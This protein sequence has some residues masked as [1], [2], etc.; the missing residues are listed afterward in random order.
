M[1]VKIVRQEKNIALLGVPTSSAQVAG[2]LDGAPAALRI[3]GIVPRLSE[4]GFSVN[5][6]GDCTTRVFETDDEH[7]RARNVKHVLA[8]LEELRPKVEVVIKSGALPLVLGGDSSIVLATVAGARRYFRNVSLIFFDRDAALKEPATT[9]SGSVD[10]M[11]ISHVLGRGAPEL[12]R[13][14]GEPPLVR[15]PDVALFGV[16]TLDEAE[17]QF[18]GRSPLR[19]YLASDVLRA[20]AARAAADALEQVHG[21]I[22]EFV[23]LVDFDVIA[24]EEFAAGT[25]DRTGGMPLAEFQRALA[26]F[27]SQ[28][29]LTGIVISGYNPS[30]DQKG[31]AAKQI[32]DLLVEV[33]APRLAPPAQ[34]ACCCGDEFRKGCGNTNR[35]NWRRQKVLPSP[36]ADGNDFPG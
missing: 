32:I 27:A 18:L 31:A 2:G 10:G 34:A 20:G 30:L 16:E 29:T 19:R 3:G 24:P 13:F 25:P 23:L 9:K 5:D 21:R 26:V 28:P 33:L 36:S 35:S 1:A 6:Y 8:T 17:Q 14:W 11:I 12:V 15:A 7:P 4:A 22:H